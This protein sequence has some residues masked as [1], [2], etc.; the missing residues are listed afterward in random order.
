MWNFVQCNVHYVWMRPHETSVRC[1]NLLIRAQNILLAEVRFSVAWLIDEV[2]FP[3]SPIKT[4]VILQEHAMKI[5]EFCATNLDGLFS[6]NF[7]RR[8]F[9]FIWI[10]SS[11][12]K[13]GWHIPSQNLVECPLG[14]SQF[15]P[16]LRASKW[17][18]ASNLPPSN[19]AFLK[20]PQSPRVL[21]RHALIS[22]C[23]KSKFGRSG[24]TGDHTAVGLI[25][26]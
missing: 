26:S 22:Y 2:Q 6:K 12:F 7:F 19:F 15:F 20:E 11:W 3:L 5:P 18:I 1:K 8:F 17:E 21:C 13:L 25:E 9:K 14:S 16:F 24:T 4:L 23:L 10:S